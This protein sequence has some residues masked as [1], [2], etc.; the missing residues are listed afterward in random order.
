MLVSPTTFWTGKNV[1]LVKSLD[2]KHKLKYDNVGVWSHQDKIRKYLCGLLCHFSCCFSV[3]FKNGE[4]MTGHVSMGL[5]ACKLVIR[6][7]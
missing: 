3:C 4:H 6:F 1:I 5:P 7:F 2:S